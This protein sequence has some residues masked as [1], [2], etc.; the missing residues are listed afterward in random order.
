[1]ALARKATAADVPH[2][3]AA[4]AR[5][6]YDD[7]PAKWF[8]PDGTV[9]ERRLLRWFSLALRKLY[10]R[11]DECYTT[12]ER[13]GAALWV[14]P[15]VRH[16]GVLEQ[17]ALLPQALSLFG[18]DL[19]R[20]LRAL[21]GGGSKRLSQPHYYLPFMG[22]V[23][24]QQRRGIGSAL[25]APVL[26]RCDRE[27]V[28]AYLEATTPRNARFYERHGFTT[29]DQARLG[30]DGPPLWLMLRRPVR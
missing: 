21:A 1:M 24:E 3:S 13:L 17:I 10:L 25:I 12:D 20:V 9:R 2:L 18:R 5:A 19:P 8:F 6:F 11:H 22:V 28:D 27:G 15:A 23:P 29:F 26:E 7:P 16:M 30:G 14:P 4:L